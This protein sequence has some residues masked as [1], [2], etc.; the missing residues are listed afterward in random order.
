M[1]LLEIADQIH[2]PGAVV[3]QVWRNPARQVQLVRVLATEE[4]RVAPLDGVEARAVG[5]LCGVSGTADVVD[6]SVVLLARRVDGVAVTSDSD[7]LRG[8]D[9]GLDLVEC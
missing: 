3:A 8:I 9:P 4:V 2:V 7:D 1:R 5:Q 6:A